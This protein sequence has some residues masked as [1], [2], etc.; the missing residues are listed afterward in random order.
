MSSVLQLSKPLEEPPNC[1]VVKGVTVRTFR[2]GDEAAWL[3]LRDQAF[4]RE[5]LGVRRWTT[6]DFEAEFIQK[7]WWNPANMW[8]AESEMA[9]AG[10][11]LLGSVTLARRGS[12][13]ASDAARPVVHWLMVSP[14]A[15][16]RGIGRALLTHLERAAFDAGHRQ[17][18]LETHSAWRAAAKFYESLGYVSS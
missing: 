12:P 2:P 8:L 9:R 7:W 18:W 11:P 10:E 14:A 5:K 13:E 4:A 3:K 15:R 16:R 6:A 17:V 1:L